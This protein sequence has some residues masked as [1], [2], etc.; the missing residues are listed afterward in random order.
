MFPRAKKVI[1]KHTGCPWRPFGA[2]PRTSRGANPFLRRLCQRL[3]RTTWSR[4]FLTSCQTI[5]GWFRFNK[6][7]PIQNV[8]AKCSPTVFVAPK[9]WCQQKRKGRTF[10]WSF[11]SSQVLQHQPQ[12]NHGVKAGLGF[13][14]ILLLQVLIDHVVVSKNRGTPKWMVYNGKP[15]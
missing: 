6:N 7:Q 12:V 8:S 3:P 10:R 15:Y 13:K 11:A 9:K 5:F 4:S 2:S 14:R 1:T